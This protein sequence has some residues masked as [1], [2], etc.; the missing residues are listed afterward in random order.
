MIQFY[1]NMG[2]HTQAGNTRPFLSYH[3]HNLG[4]RLSENG[5]IWTEN[6]TAHHL[7]LER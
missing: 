6:A 1:G 2:A 7:I 5:K 3:T 4:A